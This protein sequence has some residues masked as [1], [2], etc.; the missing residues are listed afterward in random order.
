MSYSNESIHPSDWVDKVG[1]EMAL[2]LGTMWDSGLGHI[3]TIAEERLAWINA[4][5]IFKEKAKKALEA[6]ITSKGVVEINELVYDYPDVAVYALKKAL[7]KDAEP[8]I[9][10]VLKEE[11]GKE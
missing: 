8:K 5:A 3:P 11:V 9:T 10:T 7:G 4:D 6:T 2:A 1:E